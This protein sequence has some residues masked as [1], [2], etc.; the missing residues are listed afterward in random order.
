MLQSG[1]LVPVHE[2]STFGI[3]EKM[4]ADI[5]DQQSLEDDLST[6]ECSPNQHELFLQKCR[7]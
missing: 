5:G 6:Y 1:L 4:F 3:F 7:F 2:E